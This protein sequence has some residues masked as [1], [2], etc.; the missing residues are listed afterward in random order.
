MV[1]R[2]LLV[3]IK[4]TFFILGDV[5]L[6]IIC[7]LVGF[8]LLIVGSRILTLGSVDIARRFKISTLAISL[9]I[10]SFATAI[11]EL[12]I[13]IKAMSEGYNTIVIY[14]LIGSN[15]INILFILG[16][17]CLIKPIKL[18]DN[19]IKKEIPLTIL[20]TILFVIIALDN[21]FSGTFNNV[22]TRSDALILI[23]FFFIYIYYMITLIKDRKEIKVIELPK[24]TL[25]QSSFYIILGFSMIIVGS[26]FTVD[27]IH[28][29]SL[30]GINEKPLTLYLVAFSTAIPELTTCLTALKESKEDLIIGNILGSN[31]FNICI[32]LA[33][34]V[35]I[36][37]NFNINELSIVDMINFL[38]AAIILFIFAPIKN[39]IGK[40]EGVIMF[41]IFMIYY[42]YVLLEGVLL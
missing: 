8:S 14:N 17:I 12:L 4:G 10:V 26:I 35:I 41:S 2:V 38:L 3:P 7:L 24:N 31:I 15:I 42:I 20:A 13:N 23:L 19:T 1:P 9:T 27:M 36:F 22:I 30:F 21:L 32:V 37:G 34:P 33:I 6:E 28:K 29:I 39:K 16:I 18:N 5:M 11:P 25:M 40:L